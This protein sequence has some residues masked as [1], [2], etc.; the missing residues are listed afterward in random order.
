MTFGSA[1]V[2][3]L[4][5]C[6]HVFFQIFHFPLT[7]CPPSNAVWC[8]LLS[9][10]SSASTDLSLKRY[11]SDDRW[12]NVE[13]CYVHGSVA[14]VFAMSYDETSI[15]NLQTCCFSGAFCFGFCAWVPV[16]SEAIPWL[17]AIGTANRRRFHL[18]FSIRPMIEKLEMPWPRPLL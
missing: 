10:E 2:I 12:V 17:V 9:R 4:P 18:S 16:S 13:V 5:T 14:M 8:M 6:L 11:A 1:V 15:Q 3:V 7:F